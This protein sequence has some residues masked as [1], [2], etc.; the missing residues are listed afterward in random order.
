[1]HFFSGKAFAQD[2]EFSR[3]Y[4]NPIYL[5]PALAGITLSPR[6]IVNYRNQWP[7]IG[8]AFVTY[9]ASYDMYLSPL[10]GGVGLDVFYDQAGGG[11]MNT[12]AI[13]AMYAYKFN[14][15]SRIKASGAI[16]GGYYQRNVSTA[17][18]TFNNQSNWDPVLNEDHMAGVPDFG[19]GIF[20]SYD[21]LF[22][23]GLA[24][25][26]LTQP[27]I[28]FNTD[29]TTHLNMKY[30]VHIGSLINLRGRG[31]VEDDREFSISPNIMYQQQFNFH[32]LNLGLYLT[33]DPFVG[34]LWLRLNFENAD[35]LI[36]MLGFHYKNL[37]IGFSY[38]YTIG[39]LEGASGGAYEVSASWQFSLYGKKDL[40]SGQ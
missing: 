12:F 20:L 7:G 4:A 36:P 15:T 24:V 28:G 25:D 10:H 3:F 40:S 26:H 17:N 16:K 29:S 5:N 21:D 32:Q 11:S 13:S 19:A 22:Y 2:P 35:A 31:N 14:I 18:L 37:R 27:K 33:I 30:T 1:M 34:G 39:T 6:A 38:D 23:G 9:H 8:K